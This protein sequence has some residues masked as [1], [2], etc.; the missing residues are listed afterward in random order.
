MPSAPTYSLALTVLPNGFAD[1]N[2]LRLSVV[3]TPSIT[4]GQ[5]NSTPPKDLPTTVKGSPFDGWTKTLMNMQAGFVLS[6]VFQPAG[7]AAV[8]SGSTV[9]STASLVPEMWTK[10]FGDSRSATRRQGNNVLLDAWRLSHNIAHL[11]RRHTRLRNAHAQ[12][13]LNA[14]IAD[15]T[16]SSTATSLSSLHADYND[17]VKANSIPPLYV[18]P[19]QQNDDSD[20]S[21]QLDDLANVPDYTTT[22]N[23]AL[24]GTLLAPLAGKIIKR[25]QH[26]LHVLEIQE[27]ARLQA[28]PLYC[29]FRH[30]LQSVAP[31]GTNL[32]GQMPVGDPSLPLFTLY[33]QFTNA[34]TALIPIFSLSVSPASNK[35]AQPATLNATLGPAFSPTIAATNQVTFLVNGKSVGN[36]NLQNG[37]ATFNVSTPSAGLSTLSATYPPGDT[38]IPAGRSPNLTY[39]TGAA[40]DS[41]APTPVGPSTVAAAIDLPGTAVDEIQHYIE[42]LLF[43]RRKSGKSD[44]T[45]PADPDFH[46]LLGM[47]NHYPVLLRPLGLAFDIVIPIPNGLK[48]GNYTVAA[49]SPAAFSFVGP[50]TCLLTACTFGLDNQLF[51]SAPRDQSVIDQGYLKLQ[52][53]LIGKNVSTFSFVQDDAD[54]TVLKFVD[55]SGNAARSS[56]YSS[57][58]PTSLSIPRASV[59]FRGPRYPVVPTPPSTANPVDAPPSARTVGVALFH[60][61]RLASLESTAGNGSTIDSGSTPP[62]TLYAEDIMLGLRVDIKHNNRP[63]LALCAR[64]SSYKIHSIDSMSDSKAVLPWPPAGAPQAAYDEGFVGQTA[65]QSAVDGD[66]GGQTQLHQSLFTWTGWSLALPKPDGFETVNAAAPACSDKKV[67]SVEASYSRPDGAFLPPLRFNDAYA[68]RC[69]VVDLAG[70]SPTFAVNAD[71]PYSMTLDPLFSRHDPIRA[72]QLLLTQPIDRDKSPGENID[73]LVARDGEE[74]SPRMLVPPRESLRMAEL[75]NMVNMKDPLPDSAFTNQFLMPDGSFPSVYEASRRGWIPGKID[76]ADKTHYQD[77]LFRDRKGYA[78]EVKNNFY[79]DPLAHYIRVRP[80]LVSDDPTL[81]RPLG[82]PF[83]IEID[84]EDSWPNYLAT[85]VDLNASPDGDKPTVDYSNDDRPPTITVNLP[86]GYT[87]VLVVSSASDEKDKRKTR[88]TG[89]T[90]QVALYQFHKTS[91]NVLEK[92]PK[93]ISAQAHDLFGNRFGRFWDRRSQLKDIKLTQGTQ[94]QPNVDAVLNDPTSYT[95]GDLALVTPPRTITFIHAVKKPMGNPRFAPTGQA[96]DLQVKRQFGASKASIA[97]AISAHWLTTSKIT[98]NATWNDKIDD[99][100]SDGPARNPKPSNDVAFAITAADTTPTPL[101]DF[102]GSNYLRTLKPGLQ[103]P[104][105]DTRAHTVTYTLT[106]ATRFVGYYEEKQTQSA[107]DKKETRELTV[108]S[109]AR[110]PAPSIAYIVPAFLWRDTYDAKTHTWIS[111][112]DVLLRVYLKRPYLVS[113]DLEALGIA[114]AITEIADDEGTQPLVSR[115]G[116]DPT[117]PIIEPIQSS[118]MTPKNLCQPNVSPELC[119]LAEGGKALIKACAVHYAPDRKLW[120][121]D[122]PINTLGALGPFIRLALVRWQPEALYNDPNSKNPSPVDARISPVVIADFIQLSPDRW[123]SVQRKSDNEFAVAVS[124]VLP[125][126]LAQQPTFTVCLYSRWYSAGQDTGW[127]EVKCQA[128]FQYS[129]PASDNNG[130][131]NPDAMIATYSTTLKVKPSA[132]VRKYRF[133]LRE[134]EYFGDGKSRMIYSQFVELP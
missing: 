93:G 53:T 64:K 58:A 31:T 96:G 77:A 71:G 3:L 94:S 124:G 61:G 90:S 23:S 32:S 36:A 6:F 69:R 70:N 103:Q 88:R 86:H 81:S 54:G 132:F 8:P 57:A 112:R 111:G 133:L 87:V 12:R 107:S 100:K 105:N 46:Q 102:D 17:D 21:Q 131:L 108:L 28:V 80:F 130:P 85:I 51:Y 109:S 33:Q 117:R 10:I 30:C 89:D 65:T 39:A 115:W 98:C 119:Q 1:A 101:P 121:A 41:A 55:Q 29:V 14:N 118:T 113:G 116:A 128:D 60:E 74:T 25:I 72:P 84:P 127:R 114:M 134:F 63:W 42:T 13:A 48:D 44:C 37:V 104:F 47:V 45:P 18:Y 50:S 120:Y 40:T 82:E 49:N 2:H 16:D 20:V 34:A 43:Y 129:A 95:S 125:P 62:P 35:A 24:S 67:L 78:S 73:H 75:H 110:P 68:V 7:G 122:V 15:M 22:I 11:H 26:A 56:E 38:S 5:D 92:D 27:G 59:R 91:M 83:Y 52:S 99:P 123:V 4:P 106:A 79:P 9:V 19:T 76:P 66:P 97:A 126:P